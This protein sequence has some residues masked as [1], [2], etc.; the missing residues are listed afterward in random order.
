[1]AKRRWLDNIKAREQDLEIDFVIVT[2]R[3]QIKQRIQS[4]IGL[5]VN[6]KSKLQANKKIYHSKWLKYINDTHNS[7][8][9]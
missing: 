8:K 3:S 2:Y 6:H 1:M 9:K 5:K 7:H 4:C